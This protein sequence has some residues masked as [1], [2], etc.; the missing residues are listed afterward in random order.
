MIKKILL[1]L[2]GLL[3][4]L[5]AAIAVQPS[6]FSIT[7]SGTIGAPPDAVFP[8]VNNL[9]R[10]EAWSP[11]AKLDPAAKNTFDG[12]QEGTGAIFRWTGND[13]IG[14]GV[15]TI[16][17]SRPPELVRL[18]LE[19][20]KPMPGISTTEFTF[21]PAGAQ[22]TVTW[23]MSGDNNFIG[24]ACCLFMNM[25]KLVGGQFEQGLANLKHV[26]ETPAKP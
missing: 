9:H 1:V 25:D 19:F 22:T 26:V 24:K 4:V 20:I 21:A 15:M 17:E 14:E 10:W 23:T 2:V 12:P 6:H 13:Q 3:S 18:R 16:T 5:L 7:R 11:W 8:H